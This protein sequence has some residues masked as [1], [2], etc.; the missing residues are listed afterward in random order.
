LVEWAPKVLPTD[1]ITVDWDG[2]PREVPKS[3][4]LTQV[5]NHGTEHRAQIMAIM[6]QLGVE[7]PDLQ[8]WQYFDEVAE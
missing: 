4:L 3:I 8:P 1:T 2:T 6:T 7:P 5:I